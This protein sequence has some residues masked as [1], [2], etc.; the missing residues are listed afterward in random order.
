MASREEIVRHATEFYRQLYSSS[1]KKDNPIQ[2]YKIPERNQEENAIIPSEVKA[3]IK[4]T[5]NGK[6]LG[7]DDIFNEY[8]ELGSE[9]LVS[10]ITVLFNMI[11]KP[12][13]IPMEWK[14]STIILLHKKGTKD[15]INNYRPISL[16]PNLYR[17]F[18]KIITKRMTK[19]LDENQPVEQGGFRSGFRKL[20]HLQATNQLI[21][22]VQEFNPKV[23]IAFVDYDKAFD[24]V[25]HK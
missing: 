25:E 6:C 3:A 2:N 9:D 18:T 20:D 16:L 22:K 8:L 5:K 7:E 23:F 24:S 21:E 17:L 4:E 13:E 19:I 12:E 11:L 15:D 10:T 14:Q 1:L